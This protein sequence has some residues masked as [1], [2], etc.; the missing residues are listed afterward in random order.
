MAKKKQSF[1]LKL[2][3][4][5]PYTSDFVGR[6]EHL[7]SYKKA[8][9]EIS[10]KLIFS[11]Y[12]QGG[13]GKT[14]LLQE[15]LALSQEKKHFTAFVDAEDKNLFDLLALMA[16]LAKELS[17]H[18]K[19]SPFKDFQKR[20]EDYLQEKGQLDADPEAPKGN[21]GS[22]LTKSIQ[23]GVAIGKEAIPGGNIIPTAPT[24]I[25]ANAAG[26]WTDF[27]IKK[28]S[29]KNNLELVLHP[30]QV[31]TPLWITGFNKIEEDVTI[32]IDTYEAA[33][34]VLDK[35][36]IQLRCYH[37]G[38]I[39]D[40]F[41]IIGGRD[42]LHSERWKLL[43]D[44]SCKISLAAFTTAEATAYL[45]KKGITDPTTI[46]S[47]LAISKCLPV[48]LALLA[49][50][51]NDHSN[52]PNEQVVERFLKHLQN[53][54][55]K[56]LALQ[57]ALSNQL[58]Q[59]IIKCLLPTDKKANAKDYFN[60]L[61]KR[62][63]VQKRGGYW[64]YHPIVKE[65]MRRYQRD[66]S[67]EEWETLHQQLRGY[68][69]QRVEK[70]QVEGELEDWV[71]DHQWRKYKFE[72]HFHGLCSHY[73]KYL[74]EVVRD[75]AS[76]LVHSK[77]E[78]TFPL[79]ELIAEVEEQGAIE[80]P[81]GLLLKD[82]VEGLLAEVQEEH[83]TAILLIFQRVNNTNWLER[84]LEKSTFFFVQGIHENN[85]EVKIQAYQKAIAI[86]PDFH[87][88]LNNLG[89]AYDDKGELD[90]AIKAYNKAL[91]IKPDDHQA[92]YNLGSAY[93]NK[94]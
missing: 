90:N 46:D 15:F 53:P 32:F 2:Q 9:A 7:E 66:V 19:K 83:Q 29:H 64:G 59:D 51:G 70:E 12:G 56:N 42:P 31:L 40:F 14:T 87:D 50:T 86:H 30:I 27:V 10:G 21:I 72:Y 88:A 25:L 26:Q 55:Q 93:Y 80:Q 91:H 94:G 28:V 39:D 60:W 58:N 11:V 67:L 5:S 52:D 18:N 4:S 84:V 44:W 34:P 92:L 89:S 20:Y 54:I 57:A 85:L 41:L 3:A 73:K 68:Y 38:K 48:Y 1:G 49:E 65:L 69:Q 37:Y 77:W 8:L 45:H 13:V 75:F 74:P 47:I 76:V 79:L 17:A 78:D 35:W 81:W 23:T 36:L 62:P 16:Y 63:F 71:Q 33:N 6:E 82:G 43:K 24:D 22:F 61:K